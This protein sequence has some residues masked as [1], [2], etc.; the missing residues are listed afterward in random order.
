MIFWDPSKIAFRIPFIDYPIAWYGLL[1]ALGF[2]M[3]YFVLRRQFFLYCH[4]KSLS[5]K[6]SDR[7]IWVVIVATLI[8]ARLGEVFFYSW[9]YYKQHP[10]AIFKIWEGGLASHGGVIAIILA[11]LFFTIYTKK[12]IKRFT[13]FAAL[14]IAVVPAA[15]VAAFI[16]I[17]NFINQ[18]ILGK[19]ADLPWSIVFGHP[20]D[21]LVIARHP[22]QLYEALFYGALFLF[23]FFQKKK[24]G[25]GK[26][27]GLFFLLLFSFRFLVEFIK[28]PQGE[29]DGG[30]L[31]TGQVLSIPFILLG[32]YMLCR[33]S[34]P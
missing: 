16:R 26:T 4:D 6:L 1:F 19:P 17:G 31:S 12:D 33:K 14:D 7:M 22:V 8:G 27:A 20:E 3:G 2:C 30:L 23:L 25:S 21:G 11:L 13:F 32:L 24:P 28:M 29:H 15:L 9:S 5:I 18:E 34:Q 10:L